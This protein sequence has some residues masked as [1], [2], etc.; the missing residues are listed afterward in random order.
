MPIGFLLFLYCIFTDIQ[1]SS[2]Q[3]LR[4]CK[5]SFEGD[6]KPDLCVQGWA[7][8][9]LVNQAV[10]IYSPRVWHVSTKGQPRFCCAGPKADKFVVWSAK[11]LS[12]I[13]AVQHA[14]LK[15]KVNKQKLKDLPLYKKRGRQN[16]ESASCCHVGL[17]EERDR[18]A[19]RKREAERRA[20]RIAI[21]RSML[22]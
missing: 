8:F 22:W 7:C 9:S 3:Y 15:A 13:T 18:A 21:Q 16:I 20:Q 6:R 5:V 4:S 2:L 19:F 14:L 1:P 11:A 10:N 12:R 17:S